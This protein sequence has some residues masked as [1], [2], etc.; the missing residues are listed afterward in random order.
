MKK[1]HFCTR[2]P[3]I[4]WPL[5][6]ARTHNENNTDPQILGTVQTTLPQKEIIGTTAKR[7]T[8]YN[9]LD[10]TLNGRNGKAFAH[11]TGPCLETQHYT[12]SP[13]QPEFTSTVLRPGE[14]QSFKTVFKFSTK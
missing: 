1:A 12:D 14:K 3:S 10:G 4:R 13:N 7:D 9:F 11:R 8:V 5:K 6:T 2:K